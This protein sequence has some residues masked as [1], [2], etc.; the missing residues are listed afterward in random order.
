MYAG[1]EDLTIESSQREA[2]WRLG[3]Y[4]AFALSC[5]VAQLHSCNNIEGEETCCVSERGKVREGLVFLFGSLG[6]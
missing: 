3:L 1:R 6:R 5:L 2:L 4:I